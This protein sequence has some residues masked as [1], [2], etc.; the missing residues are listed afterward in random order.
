MLGIDHAFLMRA[1]NK[2]QWPVE[3]IHIVEKNRNIHRPLGGHHVIVHPSAV[4]L[5]PLPHIAFK[6]HL[7]VDF[8]LMHV[9]LLAQ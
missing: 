5:M 1:G 6:S 7:A 4:I 9:K 8:E 2:H 3:L